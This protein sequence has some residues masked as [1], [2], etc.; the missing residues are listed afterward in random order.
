MAAI[1]V[2]AGLT[3]QDLSPWRVDGSLLPPSPCGLHSVHVH[4]WSL[5]VGPNVLS[6]KDTGQ[7]G[8]RPTPKTLFN[9]ND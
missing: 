1:E 3:C 4:S 8:L 2:S 5:F 7:V 9:L 6:K